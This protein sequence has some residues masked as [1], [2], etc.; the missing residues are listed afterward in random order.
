[1]FYPV[2]C[3]AGSENIASDDAT[4]HTNKTLKNAQINKFNPCMNICNAKKHYKIK[5][6]KWYN[7]ISGIM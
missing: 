6:N 5:Y 1:M 3:Q 2:R 7:V 4:L